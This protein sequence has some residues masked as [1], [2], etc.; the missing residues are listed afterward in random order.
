MP[1]QNF[2]MLAPEIS[3]GFPVGVLRVHD[4]PRSGNRHRYYLSTVE[5]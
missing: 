5:M 2:L 1:I 4:H 3:I